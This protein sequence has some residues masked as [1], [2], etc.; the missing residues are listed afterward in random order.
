M[1]DD[2]DQFVLIDNAVKEGF[3]TVQYALPSFVLEVRHGLLLCGFAD[4]S[5]KDLLKELEP[6]CVSDRTQEVSQ[7]WNEQRR[8]VL[9]EA[10]VERILPSLQPRLHVCY[11]KLGLLYDICAGKAVTRCTRRYCP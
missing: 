2:S 11:M 5:Q 3:L 7:Q 6:Y 9:T 4:V 8:K 1:F 10:I